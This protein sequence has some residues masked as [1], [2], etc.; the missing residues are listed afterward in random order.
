[1]HPVQTDVCTDCRGRR[2]GNMHSLRHF[3]GTHCTY[4]PKSNFMNPLVSV[5]DQ[6]KH[7]LY[8]SFEFTLNLLSVLFVLLRTHPECQNVM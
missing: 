4:T 2:F 6:F 7:S 1:M 3:K 8:K 5:V